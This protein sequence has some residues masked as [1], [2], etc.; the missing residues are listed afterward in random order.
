MSLESVSTGPE[1]VKSRTH[2]SLGPLLEVFIVAYA[3]VTGAI[4]A[5]PPRTPRA[6]QQQVEQVSLQSL[7]QRVILNIPV[8]DDEQFKVRTAITQDT[9]HAINQAIKLRNPLPK[10]FRAH[11]NPHAPHLSAEQRSRLRVISKHAE[12]MQLEE[13][14]RIACPTTSNKPVHSLLSNQ[15]FMPVTTQD[16]TMLNALAGYKEGYEG[17]TSAEALQNLCEKHCSIPTLTQ[18]GIVLRPQDGK[19]FVT[20]N[21]KLC[22]VTED[23]ENGIRKTVFYM[24]D[25]GVLL[26]SPY[27]IPYE[28][29]MAQRACAPWKSNWGATPT[30]YGGLSESAE[31]TITAEVGTEPETKELSTRHNDAVEI[32]MHSFSISCIEESSDGWDIHISG[33]I[34]A[35]IPWPKTSSL[36]DMYTYQLAAASRFA[37]L[38]KDGQAEYCAMEN[39]SFDKRCMSFTLHSKKEPKTITVRAYRNL[40]TQTL[41]LP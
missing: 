3:H 21:D 8:L 10:E 7:E 22:V 17:Q 39:L 31:G 13:P 14:G 9:L 32:G 1:L 24:P 40:E 6:Q 15:F 12:E 28:T 41:K 38:D 2:L 20:M 35:E 37:V 27:S 4:A 16:P 25:S 19:S 26:T 30:P 34:C 33:S 5:E 23:T 11:L 29:Q 36:Q 18:N